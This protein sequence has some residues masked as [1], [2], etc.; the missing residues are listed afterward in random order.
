MTWNE[1]KL[2]HE[3]PVIHTFVWTGK[4]ISSPEEDTV[5]NPITLIM[6]VAV[7]LYKLGSCAEYRVVA[8]QFSVHKSTVKQSVYIFCKGMMNG[9]DTRSDTDAR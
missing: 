3:S 6:R 4:G 8:N 5:R 1:T 9:Y 7:V 2:W